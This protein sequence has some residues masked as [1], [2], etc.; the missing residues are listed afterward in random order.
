MYLL[1]YI[2]KPTVLR[3][4]SKSNIKKPSINDSLN[5]FFKFISD[6]SDTDDIVRDRVQPCVLCLG[7]DILTAKKY[8]VYYDNIKYDFK[9]FLRA[10]NMLFKIFQ[11]FNI[12][13]PKESQNVWT[14]IQTFFFEINL[15]NDKKIPP[16]ENLKK[17]LNSKKL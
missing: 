1:H 14:F 13:Y 11:I 2:L 9:D 12:Q 4:T 15:K 3:V 6:P 16:L 10:L 17:F 8:Y 5:S 7:K